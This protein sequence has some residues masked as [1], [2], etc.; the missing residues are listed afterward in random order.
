MGW[1]RNYAAKDIRFGVEARSLMLQGVEELADAVK[2]TMG[3]K[4]SSNLSFFSSLWRTVIL[5]FSEKLIPFLLAVVLLFPLLH[6]GLLEGNRMGSV[7]V[8]NCFLV[9]WWFLELAYLRL[10]AFFFSRNCSTSH[11]KFFNSI[12]CHLKENLVIYHQNIWTNLALNKYN[13]RAIIIS[14]RNF[15]CF[16][17]SSCC[18]SCWLLH[19]YY[20][21]P[22]ISTLA[23]F[24]IC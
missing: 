12:D 9:S 10:K 6:E 11:S 22:Y 17:F 8:N 21:L 1:S 18:L 3:P 13:V 15:I 4:V 20:F 19:V 14:D 23:L 7:G 24:I 5:K 16:S 2:V